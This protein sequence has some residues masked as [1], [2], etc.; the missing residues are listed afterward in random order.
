MPPCARAEKR[1]SSVSFASWHYFCYGARQTLI[2]LGRIRARKLLYA[3]AAKIWS[4]PTPSRVRGGC[5]SAPLSRI[6]LPTWQ[7]VCSLQ[8]C[9]CWAWTAVSMPHVQENHACIEAACA[10]SH[11]V[12]NKNSIFVD[13]SHA[14][15]TSSCTNRIVIGQCLAHVHSQQSSNIQSAALPQAK[16]IARN[17]R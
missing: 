12:A 4:G 6:S 3:C 17:A 1:Q 2:W 8:D 10:E 14:V 11:P 16:H 5:C 9:A 7:Q 13:V 15:T